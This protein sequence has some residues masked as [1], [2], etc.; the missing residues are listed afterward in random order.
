MYVA[1][2]T[3]DNVLHI[4][5]N[6]VVSVLG[7]PLSVGLNAPDNLEFGP[8]GF[9]YVT[10]DTNNGRV[11]RIS[12]DGVHTVLAEG[13]NNPQGL[14]V[15]PLTGDLYISE[16]GNDSIYRVRFDNDPGL[17]VTGTIV[18]DDGAVVPELLFQ[19]SFEGTLQYTTVGE[20]N[21]GTSDFF[22]VRAPGSSGLGAVGTGHDGTFVF[23][24]RDLDANFAGQ[25]GANAVRQ[26]TFSEVDLSQHTNVTVTIGLTTIEPNS[27]GDR[28]E[29][30]DFVRLS[31]SFDGGR[32]FDVLDIFSGP[33][34][35]SGRLSNGVVELGAAL[36]DF[37]YSISNLDENIIFRVDA[38]TDG[39]PESLAFDNVRIEGISVAGAST[40]NTRMEG[41]SDKIILN[42]P[43]ISAL[44]DSVGDD[45]FVFADEG[46]QNIIIEFTADV[47]NDKP[48]GLTSEQRLV[49]LSELQQAAVSDHNDTTITIDESGSVVLLGVDSAALESDDFLFN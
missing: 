20:G 9:L 43:A 41:Q 47:A 19:E 36:T 16:Q 32:Q 24:G 27:G 12:S 15:D 5:P 2:T 31:A 25:S 3:D 35:G 18:N 23:A 4:A 46:R 8:G 21:A 48:I 28:F 26:V 42:Q 39:R 11:I 44:I 10:E 34:N 45:L 22:E 38:F 17:S 49:S 14:A 13:F 30:G 6:G 33:V 7:D 29:A 37:S 40:Q 1:E